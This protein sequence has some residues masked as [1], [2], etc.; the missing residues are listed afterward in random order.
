VPGAT[1]ALFGRHEEIPHT[2]IAQQGMNV[3]SNPETAS[4]AWAEAHAE[5]NEK[6][7]NLA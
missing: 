4:S 7:G 1:F 3:P 5:I 2:S 6:A